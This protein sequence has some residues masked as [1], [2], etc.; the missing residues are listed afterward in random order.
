MS[1][2]CPVLAVHKVMAFGSKVG[3]LIFNSI[4]YVGCFLIKTKHT[5]KSFIGKM[6]QEFA[7]IE[8]YSLK[9]IYFVSRQFCYYFHNYFHC[10]NARFGAFWQNG[11]GERLFID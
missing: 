2:T 11:I 1:Q 3:N 9:N 5:L 8:M 4:D 10:Q 7:L 6:L